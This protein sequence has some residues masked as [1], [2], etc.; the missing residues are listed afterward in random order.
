MSLTVALS[1]FGVR[2]P[3]GLL[4]IGM[5]DAPLLPAAPVVIRPAMPLALR[6]A[7]NALLEAI[8]GWM[9]SFAG[10][11]DSSGSRSMRLL[12]NRKGFQLLSKADNGV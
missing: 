4:I 12:R 2:S 11:T 5:L 6:L 7:A 8:R 10:S 1:G 9:K 3:V